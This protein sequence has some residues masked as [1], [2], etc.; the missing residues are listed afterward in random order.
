MEKAIFLVIA[1]IFLTFLFFGIYRIA[2]YFKLK[3]MEF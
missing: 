1:A 3:N 2:M